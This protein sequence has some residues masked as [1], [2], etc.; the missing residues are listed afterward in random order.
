MTGWPCIPLAN[1]QTTEMETG[2]I[3][4]LR[5]AI[6]NK[7]QLTHD[8]DCPLLSNRK[9]SGQGV[10]NIIHLHAQSQISTAFHLYNIP[11]AGDILG[12]FTNREQ[13]I[14]RCLKPQAGK[15]LRQTQDLDLLYIS[16]FPYTTPPLG[17]QKRMGSW[18]KLESRGSGPLLSGNKTLFSFFV[19][20]E[21]CFKSFFCFVL[22][23][24]S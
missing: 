8:S 22:Y 13:K 19:L 23:L 12:H 5:E 7:M 2:K 1:S 10:G 11:G 16:P 18:P 6:G 20:M 24:Y 21:M 15:D 14:Q 17:V 9:L 3:N 4:I